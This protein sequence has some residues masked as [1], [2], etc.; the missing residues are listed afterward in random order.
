MRRARNDVSRA[1]VKAALRS[2]DR[3]R[4]L[5]APACESCRGCRAVARAVQALEDALLDASTRSRSA[6]SSR[7]Q[8][9]YPHAFSSRN[10]AHCRHCGSDL[11]NEAI[12][13]PMYQCPGCKRT[14]RLREAK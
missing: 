8:A 5:S 11:P 10:G 12:G 4:C 3:G 1:A 7:L 14:S 2:L 6:E 9:L 13:N